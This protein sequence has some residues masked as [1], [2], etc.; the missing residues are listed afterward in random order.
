MSTPNNRIL[1]QINTAPPSGAPREAHHPDAKN[2]NHTP[3]T[4][5]LAGAGC[6]GECGYK[7]LPIPGSRD[8]SHIFSALSK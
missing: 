3:N 4:P 1:Q 8:F 2:Q 5:A 6:E 7:P